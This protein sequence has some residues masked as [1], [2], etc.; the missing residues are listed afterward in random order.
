M[1]NDRNDHEELKKIY[2]FLIQRARSKKYV[3][4]GQLAEVLGR[5]WN[6][7]R[8]K[9]PGYLGELL[10]I[11]KKQNWPAFSAIVVKKED[12][13]SGNLADGTL[14]GLVSGAKDAGFDFGDS[15]E[16]VKEQQ[17]LIFEWAVSAPDELPID[18]ED[19]ESIFGDASQQFWFVG[20][21]WGDNDQTE[22]FLT[23]GIWE[24]GHEGK[25]SE[26]VSEMNPGDRI[27]IKKFSGPK[28]YNLPFDNRNR[29][30]PCMQIKA[31]GTIIESTI[32][33]F[34]VKV[35]WDS[36]E[37]PRVWYFFSYYPTV[38]KVDASDDEIRRLILFTF[39]NHKQ[40]YDYWLRQPNWID[41]NESVDEV[42]VNSDVD[43]ELSK[44]EVSNICSDGC[45][46]SEDRLHSI[47]GK[48]NDKKNLILQ[49]PPGT[50]KT[51]LAKRIAWAL[52]GT[53][54]RDETRERVRTIQFHPSLSYEDFVRGWRPNPKGELDLI[55]G[56][57]LKS[58]EAALKRDLPYV[59]L[60][61][62]INRGNPAQIFGEILTLVEKDKRNQN[63]SMQLVYS[64]SQSEL[65]YVPDNL[66][67]IGTMNIADRSLAL[68]DF[69]FRRRFAFESL[70]PVLNDRWQEWC[71]VGAGLDQGVVDHVQRVMNLLNEQ[72]A[73]DR[74]L[75][76][77]FKIGHS[78]V[79]P[80][81]GEVIED[82]RTWFEN[83]VESELVPLL[84]E[85]WFDNLDRVDDAKNS[86]LNGL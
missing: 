47:L 76:P 46:L 32:D 34:T 43:R 41:P 56:I 74:S 73:K 54:D 83:I 8:F 75:G 81:K 79:T 13:E 15:A 58:V 71:A 82:S 51:W 11:C 78:Y 64:H 9:I 63:N 55:D 66:F 3:S 22:R 65:V 25:Y 38:N 10:V 31:T 85:Y 1:A 40:D 29:K 57:I 60:I 24:N 72:I 50:G 42:D 4:F 67:I 28:K 84:E 44:Y 45:F 20:A 61:E 62:E 14:K 37:E 19:D 80:S 27:A 70:E 53:N 35:D 6:E 21:K 2:R 5:E 86:L 69:A 18:A 48:L 7:V 23:E 30:I 36:P 17:R 39:S 16:F 33:G 59:L 49:G 77:Q 12:I 52:I 26:L 68:V